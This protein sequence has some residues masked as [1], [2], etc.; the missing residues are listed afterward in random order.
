M[1]HEDTQLPRYMILET[2]RPMEP[3]FFERIGQVRQYLQ[4]SI[5]EHHPLDIDVFIQENFS[6]W[7]LIDRRELTIDT[8]INVDFNFS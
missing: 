8:Q 3:R 2:E 5:N 4:I 7:N 6:V 1:N